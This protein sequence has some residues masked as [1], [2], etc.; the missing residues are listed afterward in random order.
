MDERKVR[1]VEAYIDYYPA[2]DTTR[3]IQKLLSTVPEKYLRGLES[4][5]LTNERALPRKDR[6][7]K[8]KS[9][10]RKYDKSLILGRYHPEWQG[11]RP[12]IEIRVDK[13]L[14]NCPRAALWFPPGREFC[15]GSVL[16]HELGHHVHHVM[17]P[18]YKEKED[19]ADD[20]STRLMVNFLRK[21]YWLV[22][23]P[24][25]LYGNIRKRLSRVTP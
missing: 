25:I 5:V 2:F 16:F 24:I 21:K 23:W 10:K 8:T 4:I 11:K 7:G 22:L 9:R 20:W 17:L 19:V 3:L 14:A 15:L 6:T 12:W 13:T 1:I 18:E